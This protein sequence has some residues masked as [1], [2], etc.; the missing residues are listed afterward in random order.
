MFSITQL[1]GATSLDVLGFD[2]IVVG[3]RVANL[4]EPTSLAL[5]GLALIAAGASLRKR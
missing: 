2:S 3:D 4:P 5:T 1:P